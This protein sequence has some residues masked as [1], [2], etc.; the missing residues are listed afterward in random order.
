MENDIVIPTKSIFYRRDV[1]DIYNRRKKNVE[2]SL[3]KALN[4]YHKN[5]KLTIQIN[6]TKFLDT[7]LHSKDGIYV[8]KLYRRQTKIPTH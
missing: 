2:D 4:S 7:N 5:I 8:T 6:P 1:D 3:F